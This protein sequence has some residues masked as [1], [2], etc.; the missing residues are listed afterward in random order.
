MKLTI[1]RAAEVAQVSKALLYQLCHENRI[2]H[3]RVGG[4]GRRGRIL[5]DEN[6]LHAFMQSCRVEVQATPP[7]KLTHITLQ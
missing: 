6:D 4:D 1:K 7:T 3:Y 5:I 2:P